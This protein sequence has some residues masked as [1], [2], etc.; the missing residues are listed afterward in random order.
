[1]LQN[2]VIDASYSMLLGRPSLRDAKIAHDL[3]NNTM[4]IRKNGMVRTMVVTKPLGTKVKRPKMLLCYNYY[5]GII[6]EEED[7]IFV[8]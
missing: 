8:T 1:M 5:N 4:T 2:S 6:D 3:G 7:I